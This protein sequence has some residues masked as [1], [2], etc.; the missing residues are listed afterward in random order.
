MSY[1]ETSE[2]LDASMKAIEDA[3]HGRNCLNS[4][5]V[6]SSLCRLWPSHELQSSKRV[7]L[8]WESDQCASCCKGKISEASVRSLGVYLRRLYHSQST[9]AQSNHGETMVLISYRIRA[10]RAQLESLAIN[11]AP[12]PS[13][14]SRS[15]LML[16]FLLGETV[17]MT[18]SVQF[19]DDFGIFRLIK[20]ISKL[21]RTAVSTTKARDYILSLWVDWPRFDVPEGTLEDF[22]RA[23]S[24]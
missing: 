13:K 2:S 4:H 12:E 22:A 23:S 20:T 8:Q 16:R 14:W 17:D 19:P 18:G 5:G 10:Y 6:N 7:N 24:L 11:A 9:E 3:L 1:T 15:Q 21:G